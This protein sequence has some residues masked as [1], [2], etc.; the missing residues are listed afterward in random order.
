MKK[1]LDK[2]GGSGALAYNVLHTALVE[3][4]HNSGYE[5]E[6]AEYEW[7]ENTPRTSMVA[8]LVDEIHE[9]GYDIALKRA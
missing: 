5:G 9:L 6:Y 7:I 8:L 1:I 3:C 2:F 4:A